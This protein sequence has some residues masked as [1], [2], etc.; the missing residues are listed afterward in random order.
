[1]S[2][3][4]D[5]KYVTTHE[6]VKIEGDIAY[7]GITDHAQSALGDLVFVELPEV[8]SEVTQGDEFAVVE[9][10]KA[11]SD[12]YAPISGTVVEVNENLEE[13]PELVNQDAYHDGWICKIKMSDASEYE[14]LL[15]A[16]D[17]DQQLEEE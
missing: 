8:D 9:S 7:V 4:N 6:W 2:S 1:M 5:R 3:L 14:G 10:V 17:Y 13:A 16:E 12:I 11:A 15:S